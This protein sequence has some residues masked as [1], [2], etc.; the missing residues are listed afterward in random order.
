MVSRA[1]IFILIFFVLLLLLL[2]SNVF[3]DA[4]VCVSVLYSDVLICQKKCIR[5]IYT[6]D[7]FRN[8]PF[9]LTGFFPLSP[10]GE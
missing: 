1:F 7:I 8:I 3:L 4:D 10:V 9:S 5:M 6:Y 2:L